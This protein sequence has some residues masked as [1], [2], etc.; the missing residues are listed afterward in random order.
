MYIL[1]SLP[2]GE[3][4]LLLLSLAP[5][6]PL[7]TNAVSPS[8]PL[9]FVHRATDRPVYVARSC[10]Y[11]WYI[12]CY[13]VDRMPLCVPIIPVMGQESRLAAYVVHVPHLNYVKKFSRSIRI[14]RS[15]SRSK[16]TDRSSCSMRISRSIRI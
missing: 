7:L 16:F 12:A 13:T 2:F 14:C 9:F 1:L 15:F 5:Q 3:K 10:F 6:Y 8:R 4:T 11:T